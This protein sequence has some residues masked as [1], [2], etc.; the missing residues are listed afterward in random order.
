LEGDITVRPTNELTINAAVT[1]LNSRITKGPL[2]P[3]NNN[4]YGQVDNPVGDPLPFT[5]AFSGVVNVDYRHEMTSGGAAF[6]GVS[7]NARSHSDA[8]IGAN[9]IPYPTGPNAFTRPGIGGNVFNI[10]GYTTTD[11][12]IGYEAKDGAWKVMLW[13][14]N[15][16]NSYYWTTVIP[17]NDSQG[18]LAGLPVTYGITLGFKIK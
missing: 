17:S 15:I 5:P 8:A 10:K 2:A 13:G 18:R 14:K 9:R 6:V 16:F 12:R 7:V 11:A 1:Y 4:I 3:K